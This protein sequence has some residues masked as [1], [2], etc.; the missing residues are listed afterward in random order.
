MTLESLSRRILHFDQFEAYDLGLSPLTLEERLHEYRLALEEAEEEMMTSKAFIPD[1]QDPN[2]E[3]QIAIDIQI[4][5]SIRLQIREMEAILER[6]NKE[7]SHRSLDQTESEDESYIKPTLSIHSNAQARYLVEEWEG[8]TV[9]DMTGKAR[10]IEVE[11]HC[12][13]DGV[14]SIVGVKEIST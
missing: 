10:K 2:R 8:G 12:G 1:P 13:S 11:F 14:D 6:I 9:C 7:F 4:D 5:P 3:I